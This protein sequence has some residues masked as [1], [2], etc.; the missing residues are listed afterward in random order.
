MRINMT[1]PIMDLD[2]KPLMGSDEKEATLREVVQGALLAQLPDDQ[3]VSGGFKAKLF[4][5]AMKV[6]KDN[7]DLTAEE[8]ALIKERIGVACLPLV[9]GRAYELLD[10]PAEKELLGDNLHV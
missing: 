9:V 10:P 1:S 6:K 7:P 5:L 8:I 4:N 3:N 2:D